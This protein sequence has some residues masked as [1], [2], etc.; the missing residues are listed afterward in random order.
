LFEPQL[1]LAVLSVLE[2]DQLAEIKKGT[3]LYEL[4]LSD[5]ALMAD[6]LKDSPVEDVRDVVRSIL[7]SPVFEELDRRSL[8]ATIIKLHPQ[9]QSMVI[10]EKSS[11]ESAST[12]IVS[13]DSLNRRKSELEEIVTKKI[14]QNSQEIG[15][16][17]SYGD[18]R[19]NHEFKAA[20][21]MQSVLMRRKAELEDMLVRAQGTDFANVETTE[22][23]I[24]TKVSLLET[25]SQT[26]VEYTIL[27]AWDSDPNTGI[28]SYLTPVAKG[29][30]GHKLGDVVML[31]KE[32]GGEREVKIEKISSYR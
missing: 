30:M 12:L 4:V 31:P 9:V 7:L 26:K 11:G 27:G 29:L 8:L 22:V 2:K 24:G 13:W 19:E 6:I 18:L 20:K 32:D 25:A 15:I 17:R 23:R 1:F 21:E 5:K 16:A 10:G 3:K 14:P 28:I